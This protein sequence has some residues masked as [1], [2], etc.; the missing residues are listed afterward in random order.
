[1]RYHNNS[2]VSYRGGEGRGKF[3]SG[4]SFPHK[5]SLNLIFN[6]YKSAL[7]KLNLWLCLKFLNFPALYSADALDEAFEIYLNT[8]FSSTLSFKTQPL[9]IPLMP[10][11]CALCGHWPLPHPLSVV[12]DR[13]HR[14]M[15]V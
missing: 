10:K 15:Y 1:M 11:C 5:F 4:V 3:P 14:Y 8:V 2:R 7:Y 9:V 12:L 13:M 6:N